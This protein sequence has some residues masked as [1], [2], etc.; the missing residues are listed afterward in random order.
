MQPQTFTSKTSLINMAW[1]LL[2]LLSVVMLATFGVTAGLSFLVIGFIFMTVTRYLF[3]KGLWLQWKV[4]LKHAKWT[5]PVFA[6]GLIGV[7]SGVAVGLHF[8]AEKVGFLHF[9]NWGWW[10]MLGGKGNIIMGQTQS[11]PHWM[12]LAPFILLPILFLCLPL[13]A[14]DEEHSFR[15]DSENQTWGERCGV[16][17]KFGLAHL[18][19]GIPIYGGLALSF[20]GMGF[21][22]IYLNALKKSSHQDTAVE[23]ASAFHAIYNGLLVGGLL[24]ALSLGMN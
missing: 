8:L 4:F 2:I 13:F 14:K 20:A 1:F 10:E 19:M 5:D 24:V 7:V 12:S 3:S 6:I 9:L 11:G 23:R 16:A 18:I 17:L 22:L 15:R 21:T